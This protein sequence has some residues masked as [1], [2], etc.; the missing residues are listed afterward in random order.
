MPRSPSRDLSDRF[1]GNRRYFA[2]PDRLR[3]DRYVLAALA[4]AA[5]V[6]WAAADL[7]APKRAVYAHTHGELANPHAALDYDCAACH[8][9]HA[10]SEFGAR[11]VLAAGDRWHDLTCERCHRGPAHH[12][13]VTADGQA[14]HDRCSNCHHDH[15]G[16]N[17]SLVRIADTHCTRCH[18]GM[19]FVSH[20]PEFRP[21][22][23]PPTRTLKFSHA[24]HMTPGQATTPGSKAATNVTLECASC[25]R[26]DSGYGTKEFDALKA[27]L[28]AR[29]E[30][31]KAVLP[32]R[33]GGRHF[34]PVNF[35]LHCR[36]CHPLRAG[37][38]ATDKQVAG[39]DLPHRRQPDQL[40]DDL[41][42]G[43]VRGL[44]AENRAPLAASAEPGGWFDVRPAVAA[45]TIREEADRMTAVALKVL[46]TGD[47]GCAKCHDVAD[48]KVLSVPD[49]TVW[50]TGARFDHTSHRA[51]ACAACHPGTAA[52]FAPPRTAL[53][54]KEPVQLP[55]VESCRAC[56]SPAGTKV[57]LADGASF[58]GGGVRHGC[59]DCHNYH[60]ADHGLRGRGDA[61]R[62]PTRPVGLAEFFTGK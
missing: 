12:A 15:G 8:R 11:S 22:K 60:A 62:F 13:N 49:R 55:G 17:Q 7:A 50:F 4:L 5:A 42:A 40:K 53:V 20:H 36:S 18:T 34:L 14:F 6:A 46:T 16:R 48:G 51:T 59:T 54:E 9:S 10:L 28:D 56:H 47:G 27:A 3:R 35:E 57:T 1:D 37:E 33:A 41:F 26:L 52:A 38:M 44:V 43:Y 58:V 2:R 30:P 39:F 31:A 25:H 32:P 23:S 61:A 29:G 19:N 24:V 21:L 45:R